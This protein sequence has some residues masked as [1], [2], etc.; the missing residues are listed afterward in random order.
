MNRLKYLAVTLLL[1]A[2][3]CRKDYNCS[4]VVTISG[5]SGTS[6][7]TNVLLINKSSKS[8]AAQLCASLS[9]TAETTN[10]GDTATATCGLN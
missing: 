1:I 7:E 10:T 8:D 3:S 5:S 6:T 4:C 2:T 9:H